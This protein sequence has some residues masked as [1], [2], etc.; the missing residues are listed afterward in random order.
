MSNLFSMF[1]AM[2]YPNL[3]HPLLLP[4]VLKCVVTHQLFKNIPENYFLSFSM[5]YLLNLYNNQGPRLLTGIYSSG[6]PKYIAFIYSL[7]MFWVTKLIYM[8]SNTLYL[9]KLQGLRARGYAG[10]AK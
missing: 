2:L 5:I 3:I 4:P 7:C 6:I 8:N 10:N 9:F 1:I